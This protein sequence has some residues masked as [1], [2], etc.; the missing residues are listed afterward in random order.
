MSG[1]QCG[2][3]ALRVGVGVCTPALLITG[4]PNRWSVVRLEQSGG[5][6]LKNTRPYSSSGGESLREPSP[7]VVSLL[8]NVLQHDPEHNVNHS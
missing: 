8:S 5:E 1:R 6:L 2:V 4:I 7:F 3:S